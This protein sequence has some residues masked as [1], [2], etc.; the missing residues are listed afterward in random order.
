MNNNFK[1]EYEGSWIG[2]DF[3]GTLATY[4]GWRGPGVLGEPISPMVERVKNWVTMGKNV[5]IMTA[6]V[7]P[8]APRGNEYFHVVA[9]EAIEKWCLGVFG[10]LL[11]ITH[12]KDYLMSELWD[13]RAI[14]VVFN[15]GE[16][17]IKNE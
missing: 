7:S 13:D 14:Q 2:V 10:F 11:P 4:H 8:I 12:E 16:R 15:T 9:R 3:D 6:R 1:N 17:L 5:R